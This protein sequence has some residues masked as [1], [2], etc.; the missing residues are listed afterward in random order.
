M[1][2]ARLVYVLTCAA[3]HVSARLMQR[4]RC[5][6]ARQVQGGVHPDTFDALPEFDGAV[7]VVGGRQPS[8]ECGF[9]HGVQQPLTR[10]VPELVLQE[11]GQTPA[12]AP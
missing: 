11:A 1:H 5:V 9:E 3:M 4:S 2:T 12:R 6:H 7:A 8:F 10:F